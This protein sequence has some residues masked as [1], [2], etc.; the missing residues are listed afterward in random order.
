MPCGQGF[1][2]SKPLLDKKRGKKRLFHGDCNKTAEGRKVTR[3]RKRRKK[4]K[5]KRKNELH[6]VNAGGL[7][8]YC[9][10]MGKKGKRTEARSEV[11]RWRPDASL[12][13]A[14]PLPQHHLKKVHGT[15]KQPPPHTPAFHSNALQ[16][17]ESEMYITMMAE[18][19]QF[20]KAVTA[21]HVPFFTSHGLPCL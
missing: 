18:H 19:A 13:P 9:M 7:V 10:C 21:V 14:F 17:R 6:A 16:L 2:N 5:N 11:V 20:R 12:Q 4:R 15:Q 8:L 1:I 3:R